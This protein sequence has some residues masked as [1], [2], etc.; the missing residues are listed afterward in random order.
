MTENK[1]KRKI[2]FWG[3]QLFA[4]H[5]VHGRSGNISIVVEDAA[6]ITAHDSYL[7]FLSEDDVVKVDLQ[8][9]ILTGG[10]EPSY[11][12]ALHLSIYRRF[13]RVKAVL[14]A[15]PPYTILYFHYYPELTPLTIEERAYFGNITVITQ[16]SP[17]ISNHENICERLERNDIAI[18][19]DHGVFAI[20][21]D[22]RY[23]FSLV[24]N[25][26]IAAQM[27]LLT[28]GKINGTLG[29]RRKS[30]AE[31]IPKYKLFSG[32]HID[33]LVRKINSDQ[34]VQSLGRE[35]GLTTIICSKVSDG[36]IA[37]S[38]HYQ[39]GKIVKV[40][41]DEEA[42]EFVFS[43]PRATWQMIFS[44]ELDPLVAKTQGKIKLNGDFSALSRWFP[45]FDRTFELWRE[46][47]VELI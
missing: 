28:L 20:G 45:V 29:E 35:Y 3:R 47:P 13:P 36:D 27:R 25:L 11:E 40:D 21:P 46:V 5:L 24:E 34:L 31:M 41:N 22:L 15:H 7:G 6:F 23:A 39:D 33:A 17:I 42:A 44:G 14:H 1:E 12:L 43:A 26:E 30:D 9:N 4:R 32:E 16:S 10:K 37:I 18:V 19:K 2:I 8:G 38:F